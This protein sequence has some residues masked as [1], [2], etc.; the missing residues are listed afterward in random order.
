MNFFENSFD[1]PLEPCY[2][3]DIIDCCLEQ[4]LMDVNTG[5]FV[6]RI[7]T[8]ARQ[9][10]K[11]RVNLQEETG[12]VNERVRGDRFLSGWMEYRDD[13]RQTDSGGRL[14]RCHRSDQK[15]LS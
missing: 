13:Y 10:G 3:G 2:H 5:H 8:A 9:S 6:R 4:D 7:R 12:E 14:W 1:F 11:G 15:C